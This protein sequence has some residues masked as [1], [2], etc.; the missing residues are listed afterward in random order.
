[1]NTPPNLIF[2]FLISL[3]VFMAVI[4]PA[5]ATSPPVNV[6]RIYTIDE[7]GATP[8][9]FWIGCILA[10]IALLV[11]SFIHFPAG[12]EGLVSIIA[13]IPIG[14]AMYA[15]FAVDMVTGSGAGAAISGSSNYVAIE[16]HSIHSFPTVAIA[17][18]ILL[19]GAIGN[20]IRI[21]GKLKKLNEM[22]QPNQTWHERNQVKQI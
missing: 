22:S 16:A 2:L 17:L 11:I 1:M 4:S 13:W 18:F 10:G 21:A 5:A 3:L 7:S 15:A 14:F 9:S 6:T 20:T 12:E 19:L 8:Y